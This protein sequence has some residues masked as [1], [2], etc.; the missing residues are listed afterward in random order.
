MP[1]RKPVK[2]ATFNG[3]RYQIDIDP[4]G[5]VGLTDC[6][7]ADCYWLRV[8]EDINTKEGLCTLLHEALHA[9]NWA[10][11]EETVERVSKEI[12]R[13]LWRLGYRVGE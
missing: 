9:E 7:N 5:I 10:A 1:K 6:Y 13:F 12:G 11:R 8:F 3:T 2:S 4:K